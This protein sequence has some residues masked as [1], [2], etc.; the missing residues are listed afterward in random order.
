MSLTDSVSL[1]HADCLADGK[2]FFS[3]QNQSDRVERRLNKYGIQ[4]RQSVCR[5]FF[6]APNYSVCYL[7]GNIW[8]FCLPLR[9][10][11][12]SFSS[13][14]DS[15]IK[16]IQTKDHEKE[17]K[18]KKIKKWGRTLLTTAW[19]N[20]ERDFDGKTENS[21]GCMY[22]CL[23]AARSRSTSSRN[24]GRNSEGRTGASRCE[25]VRQQRRRRR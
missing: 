12:F 13:S 25:T 1:C 22:A 21:G 5:H 23:P 7:L 16:I 4:R 14:S 20:R 17:K 9:S 19:K 3:K 10:V 18:E 8:R 6:F 2:N 11:F 15:L 24:A